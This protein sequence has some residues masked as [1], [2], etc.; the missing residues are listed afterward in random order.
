MRHN[1]VLRFTALFLLSFT[2]SGCMHYTHKSAEG[3]SDS[4]IAT[5]NLID[6][7]LAIVKVDDEGTL[8]WL[9]RQDQYFIGAGTHRIKVWKDLTIQSHT[10]IVERNIELVAGHTYGLYGESSRAGWDFQVRDVKT[11][12]R[13]D[14]VAPAAA[15]SSATAPH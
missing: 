14:I 8:F 6:K 3:K 13:A 1:D 2:L 4:D 11:G 5:I 7:S 15:T 9:G 10:A 12:L